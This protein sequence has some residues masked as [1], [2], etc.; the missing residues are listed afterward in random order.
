MKS[1]PQRSIIALL[2]ACVL[3]GCTFNGVYDLPLPGNK[4]SNGDSF[5]VSADFADALNVVPRSSVMVADVPVGQVESITRVGWHARVT[6]R[7]RKDVKLPDNAVAEIRQTSLLGE[8]FIALSPPS[9]NGVE[10]TGKLGP[11]DVIPMA[12][13]GR[14]P[15]VEEVLGALSFLLSGGGDC[16]T[17]SCAIAVRRYSMSRDHDDSTVRWRSSAWPSLS[18]DS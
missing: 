8:K 7:I 12:R 3:S 13:T 15:E 2:L 10:S 11:H 9:G 14:N 1:W 17:G 4:V 18:A 16:S 6:M 5:E